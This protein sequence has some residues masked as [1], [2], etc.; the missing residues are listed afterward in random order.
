MPSK[1]V[2]CMKKAAQRCSKCKAMPYCSR[3]CQKEHWVHV[4]KHECES[5]GHAEDAVDGTA[6]CPGVV[7]SPASPQKPPHAFVQALLDEADEFYAGD[8]DAA[9][10]A[11][12][13]MEPTSI[14]FHAWSAP[15]LNAVDIKD[16]R[17]WQDD[18]LIVKRVEMDTG[19]GLPEQRVTRIYLPA[20]DES[21]PADIRA[22]VALC[23]YVLYNYQVL[24]IEH[25][26]V[27]MRGNCVVNACVTAIVGGT[28]PVLGSFGAILNPRAEKPLEPLFVEYN[29]QPVWMLGS[30]TREYLV[31][32]PDVE[33][34]YEYVK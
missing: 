14:N 25:A 12:Q 4:H 22:R 15:S 16:P 31:P 5:V 13:A 21:W 2:I 19:A 32:P 10:A 24:L 9:Y 29:K 6:E 23:L 28:R 17:F 26:A 7:A 27:P 34:L 30:Q 20:E 3:A 18:A 33:A 11:F 1:C 8:G